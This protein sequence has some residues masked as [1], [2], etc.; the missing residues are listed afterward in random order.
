MPGTDTTRSIHD[1]P[2]QDMSDGA[3]VKALQ[4]LENAEGSVEYAIRMMTGPDDG[5]DWP[6]GS[7]I[8]AVNRIEQTRSR[9]EYELRQRDEADGD[10][11]V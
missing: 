10:T 6:K 1:R 4:A 5:V 11:S 9:V 7:A 8:D 2:L 3:I